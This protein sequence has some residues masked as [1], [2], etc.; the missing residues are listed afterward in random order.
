MSMLYIVRHSIPAIDPTVAAEHWSLSD[1]GA[2]AAQQ[3]GE[4]PCWQNVDIIYSS[5]EPKALQT[6]E[7]IARQW[8]TGVI[9]EYDL[10]ELQM[11]PI[12]LDNVDFVKKVGDYLEGADDPDFEPYDQAQQRI[13]DC[14]KRLI[15]SHPDQSIAIVSH[16][17]ILVAFFSHLF[18]RRVGRQEWRSI[19]MPDLAVVD[20]AGSQV[21]SG[22]FTGC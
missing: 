4:L 7:A 14:V 21:V 5:P 8:G 17:R 20:L 13:V 22:F 11:K 1:A 6:A 15:Q 9:I 10:R 19:K 3:L 12:W 18:G 2:R 16:G